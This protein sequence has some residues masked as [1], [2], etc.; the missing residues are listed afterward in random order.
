MRINGDNSRRAFFRHLLTGS[1]VLLAAA[2]AACRPKHPLAHIKGSIVGANSATGHLLRSID[3]LPRPVRTIH[4]ETLIVG[5]G[6]SGLSAARWLHKAGRDFMLVEM[7]DHL[8]GNSHHG[9]NAVSAYPWGAHYLP[10]PDVRNK[11]ILDLLQELGTI[12]GYNDN[13]LPIYNEYHLC[14]DPEERLYINGYW[15]EGLVPDTGVPAEEKEQIARFFRLMNEFKQAKGAD[16][17]DVFAIPLDNSSED[18]AYRELDNISFAQYLQHKGFTSKYLFWYLE[19]G[20]K[21]DYASMLHSTSAWAGIHYF[22]SRKGTAAN[23]TGSDVLT[24]PEGNGFLAE[25]LRKQLPAERICKQQLV[26]KITD[27]SDGVIANVYDAVKRE[28][29]NIKAGKIILATPQ[30]INKRLLADVE[31]IK[32]QEY[33]SA[34]HYAPWVIANITV[35]DIPQGKGLPLCWDN[36]IYG[37]PSVGY[38]NANH[39]DV[40]NSLKKVLTCYLPLAG[41]NPE[42]QRQQARDKSYDYWLQQFVNELEYAHPGITP[43]I[44]QADVCVWGHGMIA[45]RPGLIWGSARMVARQPI[46]DKIFFAHTDL[47]GISIFEEAF[48]QGIRAAKQVI[49]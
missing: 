5:S 14:N 17:K 24:W 35:R 6:I 33:R 30:F 28:S 34:F 23:A 11:E 47:S 9:K 39:Q 3:K 19:Y 38:V 1:S 40:N 42:R 27:D 45:P 13:G 49:A 8:G 21:D 4:T 31:D 32:A 25:G 36:V 26:Y 12:T 37:T 10:V 29:Y 41:D 18:M 7:D 15:Q 46:K 22:A 16:G 2:Y 43:Y 20:C 44:E 48:Y